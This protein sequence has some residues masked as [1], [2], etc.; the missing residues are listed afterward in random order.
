MLGILQHSG[1]LGLLQ[2]SSPHTAVHTVGYSLRRPTS[3]LVGILIGTSEVIRYLAKSKAAADDEP[4]I[5]SHEGFAL[6]QVRPGF[7]CSACAYGW[8]TP[9]NATRGLTS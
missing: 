2:H 6:V 1:I 8:R 3:V 9:A 4:Q 5:V 7:T